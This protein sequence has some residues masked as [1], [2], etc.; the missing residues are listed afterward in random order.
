[1]RSL[2]A[3]PLMVVCILLALKALEIWY[4]NF[5]VLRY[6]TTCEADLRTAIDHWR[7][8]LTNQTDN[9]DKFIN[10]AL[11]RHRR[12]LSII[13]WPITGFFARA[14]CAVFDRIFRRLFWLPVLI[15]FGT[16]LVFLDWPKWV[17]LLLVALMSA[18]LWSYVLQTLI[19]RLKLGYVDIFFRRV[20]LTRLPTYPKD[21]LAPRHERIAEFVKI[22]AGLL[23][24]IAVG[25]VG[26]Y[27]ALD[28]VCP[29]GAFRDSLAVIDQSD[30]GRSNH[31]LNL[32]DFS[33][34]SL[35]TLATVGY[36]DIIPA[37]RYARF[38]VGSEIVAGMNLLVL[39]VLSFAATADSGS[40]KAMNVSE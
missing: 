10:E 30:P 21:L 1:M 26:I 12:F 25:Y 22:F 34:F 5:W 8:A 23:I 9:P 28:R 2:F 4:H 35:V 13:A 20:S 19:T 7:D 33:Y 39:L 27:A 17:N 18:A 38:F 11:D 6:G 37:N 29:K 15:T 40:S 16:L 31:S 32:L 36:G 14:N 24:S 3:F